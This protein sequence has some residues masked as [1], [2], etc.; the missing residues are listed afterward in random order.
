MLLLLNN[1][2]AQTGSQ[3]PSNAY[4]ILFRAWYSGD[5]NYNLSMELLTEW[6]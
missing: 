5:D 1:H 2:G 3:A 4:T 6:T